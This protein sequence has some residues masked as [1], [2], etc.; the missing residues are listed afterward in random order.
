MSDTV[1]AA[2]V[3]FAALAAW[4]GLIWYVAKSAGVI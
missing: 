2:R 4:L 3:A 1:F